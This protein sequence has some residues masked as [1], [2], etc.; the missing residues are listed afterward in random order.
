MQIVLGQ[1]FNYRKCWMLALQLKDSRK[2][3]KKKTLANLLF[4]KCVHVFLCPHLLWFFPHRKLSPQSPTPILPSF[5]EL[6]HLF[7]VAIP[8]WFTL[9]FICTP[10]PY[11]C[12]NYS[13]HM[14]F[15]CY[16]MQTGIFTSPTSPQSHCNPHTHFP[17]PWHNSTGWTCFCFCF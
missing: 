6:F 4:H 10:R 8:D 12:I 16:T 14:T 1:H 17:C 7:H 2:E 15:I 13:I 9:R 11:I 3:K 5:P